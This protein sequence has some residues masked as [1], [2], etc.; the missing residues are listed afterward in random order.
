[1][2]QSIRCAIRRGY[3]S[4]F[5]VIGAGG[6]SRPAREHGGLGRIVPR[7][8]GAEGVGARLLTRCQTAARSASPAFRVRLLTLIG[9]VRR[10]AIPPKITSFHGK[11]FHLSQ[12]GFAF[13]IVVI[14]P[15]CIGG[16]MV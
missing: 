15:A 10:N 14:A 11:A 5:Q 12:H 8:V 7:N 16:L 9:M 3:R 6:F 1:M 2:V 4:R 13:M